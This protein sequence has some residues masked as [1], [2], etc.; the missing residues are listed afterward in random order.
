MPKINEHFLPPFPIPDNWAWVRLGEIGI[1]KKGPFGSSLTKSIFV[2]HSNNSIKVY[3]Q[4]NAIYKDASLGDYYITRE[5][6]DQK[7]KG[8]EV[9]PGEIIVSC[10]GTIG[11]TY[12]LPQGIEQGIINQALMKMHISPNIFKPY[13]LLYFDFIIKKASADSSKGSAIK[14]IPPFEIFKEM[15]LPLPPLSEQKRIVDKVEELNGLIDKL[16]K[17]FA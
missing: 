7:M 12:F 5:Y 4:K 11:E 2:D 10:A 13:F 6:F 17:I 9:F 1:Y 15:L 8:F 14:N 3:E 16:P